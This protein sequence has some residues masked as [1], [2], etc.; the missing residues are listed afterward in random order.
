MDINTTARL[1]DLID[2]KSAFVTESGINT[3]GDV[4]KVK[5]FGAK[6]CLIGQSLCESD[7]IEEKFLELFS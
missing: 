4:D 1:S 7:N 2:D 5:S 3:R 6:A